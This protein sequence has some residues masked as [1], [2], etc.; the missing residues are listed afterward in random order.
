MKKA[1]PGWLLLVSGARKGMIF[2]LFLF[3]LRKGINL[4]LTAMKSG[5]ILF[6]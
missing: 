5:A 6:A 3:N 1:S 4:V 2:L